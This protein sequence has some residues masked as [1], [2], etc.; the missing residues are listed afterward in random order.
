MTYEFD[1]RVSTRLHDSQSQCVLLTIHH[2]RI[3]IIC[4][5]ALQLGYLVVLNFKQILTYRCKFAR[6]YLPHCPLVS[7]FVVLLQILIPQS[8]AGFT[9]NQVFIHTWW[10]GIASSSYSHY[11]R[12]ISNPKTI[13]HKQ[14]VLQHLGLCMLLCRHTKHT[15][16]EY[17]VQREFIKIASNNITFSIPRNEIMILVRY[18]GR[19]IILM[20]MALT[21]LYSVL[22]CFHS[23]L[24]CTY[25]TA[26]LN[27]SQ[28]II[29]TNE[30]RQHRNYP[31]A[32]L[33]VLLFRIKVHQALAVS[34]Q[35]VK[36]VLSNDI[37]KWNLHNS[38]RKF[39]QD[40]VWFT[41]KWNCFSFIIY[42]MS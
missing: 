1:S 7:V 26:Y 21:C 36:I 8:R 6:R 25:K 30:W 38:L 33:P 15:V 42:L 9:S 19:I 5:H 11:R 35:R 20:V 18:C 32:A 2:K 28:V 3:R 37:T 41:G 40:N 27:R 4:L 31:M 10:R 23:N 39:I 34:I 22:L 13:W 24:F 16:V 12:N 29:W 14:S 17:R